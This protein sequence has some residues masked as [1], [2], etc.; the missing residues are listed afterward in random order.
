M[1]RG[2]HFNDKRDNGCDAAPRCLECP[3]PFCKHDDP[4]SYHREHCHHHRNQRILELRRQGLT[5][6][7]L[8]ETVG[9]T[10]RSIYRILRGVN[11]AGTFQ[12]D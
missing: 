8:A 11:D 10:D 6:A 7:Q 4:V 5:V 12:G 1:G 3:L 2:P 9:I